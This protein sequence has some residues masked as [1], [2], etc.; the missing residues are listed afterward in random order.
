MRLGLIRLLRALAIA[1]VAALPVTGAAQQDQRPLARLQSPILTVEPERLFG[2]SAFGQ[3]ITEELDRL[4]AELAAENRR[5]EA[6]LTEEEQA[7]TEQRETLPPEEFR[8]LA[9]AFDEKVQRI[10]REQDGKARALAVRSEEAR[11]AF[12][13]AAQPV[14]EQLMRDAGAAVIV[15]R[16]SIFMSAEVIDITDEAIARIDAEIGDGLSDDGL[17]DDGP[18]TPEP[19]AED[20]PAP[21]AD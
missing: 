20:A 9:D 19:Q 8:A 5:I 3:R 7:L 21:S 14:L 2:D 13:A 18:E 16:R 1:A 17:S 10:R 11:R 15:E 12:L 6:E 4:G